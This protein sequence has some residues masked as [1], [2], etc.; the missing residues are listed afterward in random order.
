VTFAYLIGKVA[1][2]EEAQELAN[3]SSS[4]FRRRRATEREE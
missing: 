4:A 1:E 2:S 3:S